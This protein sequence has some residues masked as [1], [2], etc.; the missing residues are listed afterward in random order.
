M[1]IGERARTLS[2]SPQINKAP[3]RGLFCCAYR[4]SF[5]QKSI[6]VCMIDLD[7]YKKILIKNGFINLTEEEIIKLR[8]QQDQMTEIFFAMWVDK[9]KKDKIEV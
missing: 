8:D 9:I 4:Y 3:N 6:S 7:T 2:A 5:K 1:F